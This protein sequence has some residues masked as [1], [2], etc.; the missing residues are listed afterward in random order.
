MKNIGLLLMM[1]LLPAVTLAQ[2]RDADNVK[3]EANA[4]EEQ[5]QDETKAALRTRTTDKASFIGVE[6]LSD[7][8][9]YKNSL[10]P[11]DFNVLVYSL[12]DEA[13][14]EIFVQT[15]SEESGKICVSVSGVIKKYNLEAG[16][17]KFLQNRKE[18]T[19]TD[20]VV[21][22]IVEQ[23][24]RKSGLKPDEMQPREPVIAAE[25]MGL[26]YVA[27]TEFYNGAMS[28]NHSRLIKHQLGKS[29]YF[30]ITD[31]KSIADF[32]IYPKVSKAKVEKVGEDA[33]RLQI[34]ISFVLKSADE[35][36]I[37][38]DEQS[39]VSVFDNTQ[40]EQQAAQSL[41]KTMFAKSGRLLLAKIENIQKENQD[42][43]PV[44][45][46]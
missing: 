17:E 16:I 20:A 22:T 44:A 40:T 11:H 4:C 9:K 43:K 2:S 35:M 26:V 7:V 19:P 37:F 15:I 45:T 5:K 39:R 46:K 38:K 27:P 33:G 18:E 1:F 13:L 34:E 36:E 6:N 21:E 14:E 3:V 23:N 25:D 41:L 29:P 10:N 28:E 24:E 8:A 30:F 31:D 32:I 42:S 12:V